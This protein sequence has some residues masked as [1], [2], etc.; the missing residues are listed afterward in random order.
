[1]PLSQELAEDLGIYMVSF[2]RAGYGE[3]DP[4]PRRTDKST[5]LYVEELADQLGLGSKFYVIGFSMGGQATWGCLK[6]IPHRLAGAALLTPVVNSWWP[7]FPAKLNREVFALKRMQYQWTLLVSHYAPFLTYWWNTQK[8]FP[9]SSVVSRVNDV[10]SKQDLEL[11]PR[12]FSGDR[13]QIRQQGEYVSIFSDMNVAF[14]GYTFDPM[15]LENPFS[16]DEGT[17]HVWQG[18]EDK[19]VQIPLQRYIAEKL[20]WVQYHELAGAGH[21]FPFADGMNNAIVKSLVLGEKK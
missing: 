17:V 9:S 20:P 2:D 8:W 3:S 18:D 5:A 12:L 14:G 6:Y 10:F 15:D 21:L 11:I 7:G 1:M 19:I 13:T 16:N 4:N